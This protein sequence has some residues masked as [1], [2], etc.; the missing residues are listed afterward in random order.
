MEQ[1]LLHYPEG[2]NSQYCSR[3]KLGIRSL[4]EVN[5]MCRRG[6]NT[7][8]IF[9][10]FLQ[11]TTREL[12]RKLNSCEV[13]QWPLVKLALWVMFFSALPQNWP[14]QHFLNLKKCPGN[15]KLLFPICID[16]KYRKFLMLIIVLWIEN[17]SLSTEFIQSFKMHN[18]PITNTDLI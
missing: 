5:H 17:Q 14:C 13:K 15:S 6:S 8:T 4:S 3:W 18:I 7:W 2:H 9:H 16:M 1:S 10:C 12:D 11:A